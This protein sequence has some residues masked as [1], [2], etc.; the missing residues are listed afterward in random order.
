MKG[1]SSAGIYG[2]ESKI[3]NETANGKI[4]IEEKTSAGMYAKN[5]VAENNEDATI[6][7][8][9][10]SSAGMYLDVDKANI[11]ANGT[12]KGTITLDTGATKSAGIL[13]KLTA[14]A[15]K[16]LTVT[17]EG[18][19][20][21]NGGTATEPSVAISAENSTSTVG[22]LLV[23]NKKNINLVSEKSIGLFLNKSKAINETAG[24]INVKGKD[25]TGVYAKD[26]ADF[27]NKGTITVE[28]PLNE[29]AVGIFATGTGTKVVN[30][31]DI[32][33]LS[34]NSVGIFGEKSA[35]VQNAGNIEL[36]TIGSTLKGLIGIFGESKATAE[37]VKIENLGGTINVNTESS[38]GMYANNTS[39][40]IA[41]VTLENTGT[42]NVNGKKS[43]GIY[44]PKSTVSKVGEINLTK[45]ADGASAV[46]IEDGGKVTAAETAVINLGTANQ[47]RVAYYVKNASSNVEGT[48][49]GKIMGY[50]VG[51]YLQGT[52]TSKAALNT[53][54]ATL[55]YTANGATGDG[56][57]RSLFSRR[58]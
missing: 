50:G 16:V 20:N 34:G 37:A 47:N 19:I 7:V 36:G 26:T 46:Y 53:N 54:T 49:I 11:T 38:A 45:D 9:K 2:D 31:K 58:Y 14:P 23:E 25:A 39:G 55:D 41:N 3:V 10:E 44:A 57:N 24:N 21:V 35:T 12:N 13:A 27:E 33:V 56:N 32:K 43:A 4:T 18:D 48:N 22:N 40:N 28:A 8:K 17:N 30:S 6:T 5:A 42:I 15:D 52:A 51:L 29:K 1:E